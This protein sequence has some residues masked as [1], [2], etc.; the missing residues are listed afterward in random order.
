MKIVSLSGKEQPLLAMYIA[1]G[2]D[3]NISRLGCLSTALSVDTAMRLFSGVA[4]DA[5]WN[6]NEIPDPLVVTA[7]DAIRD[8]QSLRRYLDLHIDTSD[9]K[10]FFD[11]C[12][13]HEKTYFPMR[14]R[15]VSLHPVSVLCVLYI[16]T[17]ALPDLQSGCQYHFQSAYCST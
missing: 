1:R 10:Q 3:L 17:D 6:H 7:W 4:H 5:R 16:Y 13:T 2:L 14:L 15:Y 9:C 11:F 12:K 8:V